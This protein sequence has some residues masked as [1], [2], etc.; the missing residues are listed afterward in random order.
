MFEQFISQQQV[1]EHEIFGYGNLLARF[2]ATRAGML[3]L[4]NVGAIQYFLNG[5]G[6]KKEKRETKRKICIACS[7]VCG[8][9]TEFRSL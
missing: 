3:A 1:A 8:V 5:K 2:A 6:G 9:P 4:N 7:R